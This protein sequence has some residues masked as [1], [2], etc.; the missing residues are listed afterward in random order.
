MEIASGS[1]CEKHFSIYRKRKLKFQ[2][3]ILWISFQISTENFF[4]IS[5][6]SSKYFYKTHLLPLHELRSFLL[7]QNTPVFN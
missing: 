2:I 1:I 3:S 6:T 5:Y 7:S 4:T